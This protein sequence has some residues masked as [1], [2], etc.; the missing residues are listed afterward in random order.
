MAKVIE[1]FEDSDSRGSMTRLLCFFAFIPATFLIFTISND[2]AKVN[3]LGVY[4]GAFV[5]QYIGGKGAD[6]WRGRPQPMPGVIKTG[7]VNV[8]SN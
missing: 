8:S 7:D 6:A 3:A 4:L 5:L 1:F 2:D